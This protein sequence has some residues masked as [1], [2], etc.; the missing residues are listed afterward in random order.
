LG[1]VFVALL[2][3]VTLPIVT[4]LFEQDDVGRVSM[5]QV[6]CSFAVLVYSMG[7]DQAYVREYHDANH[8]DQL[9][10]I[11]FFPGLFAL[12][13][14]IAIISLNYPIFTSWIFD[15]DKINIFLITVLSV[16]FSY[17]LRYFSL[18][19]RMQERG[20][21]YSFSQILPKLI[22]LAVIIIV[23]GF[24]FDKSFLQLSLAHL[25]GLLVGCAFL[26][27][28]CSFRLQAINFDINELKSLLNYGMP[29]V[30]GG[31]AYW[32]LTTI[33]RVALKAFSNLSEL[34]IYAVA[35]NFAAIAIIFQQVFSTIWAPM[36]YRWIAEGRELDDFDDILDYV[37]LAVVLLF[38]TSGMLSWLIVLVLPSNYSEVQYIL[39]PC[40]TLPLLYTLSEA[41]AI[42][43]NIKKKTG[44]HLLASCFSFIIGLICNFIFTPIYG[45][46]GA[47]LSTS[48][49]FLTF[50]FIRTESSRY[51]WR[52][53]PRAKSYA[54]VIS[55]VALANLFM[56][57][58][59]VAHGYFI[60]SWA[61]FFLLSC[62]FYRFS[63][64][65]FFLMI[66]KIL[67]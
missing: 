28:F 32:G 19:V 20:G 7:L 57:F 38:C 48:L 64:L 41:T 59:S 63:I 10:C 52:D 39:V 17:V 66:K 4:W 36:V 5:L 2:G 27:L 24:D 9:F 1:P 47:A 65:R 35:A 43:I 60:F 42:G 22:F 55:S 15:S 8:K 3:L 6:V 21:V 67:A 62:Y 29:L 11:A 34:S 50:F 40:M 23:W 61:V 56:F 37:T 26:F 46:K 58:G 33:D 30:F 54:L 45:A 44:Y 51:L 53:F 13:V 18:V 16:V 49:A 14:S 25:L 12:L 31:I